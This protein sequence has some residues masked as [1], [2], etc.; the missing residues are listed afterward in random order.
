MLNV[1]RLSDLQYNIKRNKKEEREYID[2]LG[3]FC[4][5]L[6]DNYNST[7]D[8]AKE[9]DTCLQ[10]S[11]GVVNKQRDFINELKKYIEELEGD[12]VE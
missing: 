6:G 7:I 11:V 2:L 8:L 10:E 12:S 5:E 9:L 1:G 4:I 3:D